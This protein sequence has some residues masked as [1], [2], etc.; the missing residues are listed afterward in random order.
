MQMVEDGAGV[1]SDV[2]FGGEVGGWGG[3]WKGQPLN[4]LLIIIL[5]VLLSPPDSSCS[6]I[7]T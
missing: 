7:L 5:S 3:Q 2:L 6:L 1:M 4:L